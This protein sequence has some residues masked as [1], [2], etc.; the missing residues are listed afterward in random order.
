ML[1][2]HLILIMYVIS[3][4]VY[5]SRAGRDLRNGLDPFILQMRKVAQPH[6][7]WQ[8]FCQKWVMLRVLHRRLLPKGLLKIWRVL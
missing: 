3:E 8:A 7:R 2:M 5:N 6:T 1:K 4:S